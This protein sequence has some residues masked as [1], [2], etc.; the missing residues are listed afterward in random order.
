MNS[1]VDKI[2]EV[3]RNQRHFAVFPM[4]CADHCARLAEVEFSNAAANGTTLADVL[5]YGYE[6]YR[7]DMVLVFS[8]PYVEAQALGCP[9]QLDPYPTLLGP[10]AKNPIDRTQEII[11]AAEILKEEIDVPVFVSIKGPFTLAAF[12]GGIER[13]L[14]MVLKNETEASHLLQDALQYQLTYLEKLLSIGVNIM[15]GDPLASSSVISPQIFLKYAFAGLKK[16]VETSKARG[17]IVGVHICGD[18][19]PI[20]KNLDDLDADILSTE[21]ICIR[22]KTTGMGGVGTDTLLNGDLNRIRSEV[23]S[24]LQH[25]PLILSTSCDVPAQTNPENIKAML[26]IANDYERE[27]GTHSCS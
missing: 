3:I 27:Q 14:K 25:K 1:Y 6:F 21:N 9:V 10:V 2:S 26:R 23:V 20:L 13:Y 11:R 4:V 5:S 17:V 15:I 24:A 22:T 7:Y 16:I 18:V 12:L 8:D 19:G